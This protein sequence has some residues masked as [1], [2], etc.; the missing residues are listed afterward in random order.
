[1]TLT[2]SVSGIKP[3]DGALLHYESLRSRVLNSEGSFSEHSLGLTLFIR[4]GMLAWM[5][6]CHR[7]VPA[8]PKPTKHL[9]VPVFAYAS[10]MI[11]VMANITLFNLEEGHA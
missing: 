10:E 4:R 8:N 7:C 3:D 1:M 2:T 9:K 6:A 11:K 5:E